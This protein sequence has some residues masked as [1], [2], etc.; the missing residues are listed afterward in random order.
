MLHGSFSGKDLARQLDKFATEIGAKNIDAAVEEALNAVADWLLAEM[1]AVLVQHGKV[2]TS[3]AY[4]ALRRSP[5]E[6]EGNQ[7]YIEVGGYRIRAEDKDGF[8]LVYLEYG[9]THPL[10]HTTQEPIS[11]LR[12]TMERKA[13]IRRIIDEIFAKWGVAGGLANAA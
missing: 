9:S 1:Q 2:K 11:W 3:K 10:G 12:S 4:D 5:V 13:E 6:H 8:H 7:M